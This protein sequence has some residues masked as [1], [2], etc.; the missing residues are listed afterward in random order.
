MKKIFDDVFFDLLR[1]K[2]GLWLDALSAKLSVR[3]C[4]VRGREFSNNKALY[5]FPK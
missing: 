2:D 1:K 5:Y 3:E 4:K